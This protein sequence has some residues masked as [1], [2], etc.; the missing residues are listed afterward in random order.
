MRRRSEDLTFHVIQFLTKH[1]YFTLPSLDELSLRHS[2]SV[3]QPILVGRRWTHNFLLYILV[4]L[5]LAVKAFVG[6]LNIT[7]EGRS[8]FAMQPKRFPVLRVCRLC[9][10]LSNMP[11]NVLLRHG[12][13]YITLQKTRREVEVQ[14]LFIYFI[15]LFIFIYFSWGRIFNICYTESSHAKIPHYAH[16]I[17]ASS[18]DVCT[19]LSM[20]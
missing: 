5:R 13:E 1:Q 7:P 3:L 9:R 11:L 4:V 15:Y 8:I 16:L 12:W 6:N 14:Y 20:V 10:L 2:V 19:E 18:Q 17:D